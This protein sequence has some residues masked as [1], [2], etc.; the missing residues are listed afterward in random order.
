MWL[1][2]NT[3]PKKVVSV[4]TV[5]LEA[6]LLH[7]YGSHMA[8]EGRMPNPVTVGLRQVQVP[9]VG[10]DLV[11][12]NSCFGFIYHSGIQSGTVRGPVTQV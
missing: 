12:L 6:P 1:T 11:L 10:V 8:V 9:H 5:Q 2:I 3:M 4:C 7:A